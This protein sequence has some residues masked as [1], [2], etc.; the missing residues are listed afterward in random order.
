MMSTLDEAGPPIE[1]VAA[2]R[3]AL[4]NAVALEFCTIPAYLSGW[5]TIKNRP[6]FAQTAD[7]LL[8]IAVAEM[9]HMSIAC[10]TLI[11][12]GGAPDVHAAVPVYPTRLP[13]S[14]RDK[15]VRLLPFG[16]DF[17]NLGLFVEQ[18]E[19]LEKQCSAGQVR[20][21]IELA[22][23][24]AA[25]A[26]GGPGA[27]LAKLIPPLDLGG[28]RTITAFYQ[29]VIEGIGQLVKQEGESSVFPGGGRTHLQYRYFGGQDDITVA[30]SGDAVALLT[31]I[32]DEGEGG[33]DQMWDE[34]G[35][36]SHYYSFDQFR[37]KKAYTRGDIR[38]RPTGPLTV[39]GGDQ[40]IT[41]IRDPMMAKYANHPE[42]EKQANAF[43]ELFQ[44]LVDNLHLGF[45]GHPQQIDTAVG[46]MHQL[47]AA[48]QRVLECPLYTEGGV[49]YYA[50]PT[51]EIPPYRKDVVNV[52]A[53]F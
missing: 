32:I 34:N 10:N 35:V 33:G 27:L 23:L 6:E 31:D 26:D 21:E 11:A 53:T 25:A 45:N 47:Q 42:A 41:I 17:W 37:K 30:A 15:L 4:Q 20:G 14:T 44:G 43:N 38:C 24:S 29:A 12:V 52:P 2:L 1:S 36:L 18:P 9:K 39:P 50:A 22:A 8:S 46:Q 5:L 3:S 7:C 40:V 13:D 48:A 28:Y 19:E 49:T 51:F 16:E